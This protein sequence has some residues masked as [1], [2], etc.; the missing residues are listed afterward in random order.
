VVDQCF[1]NPARFIDGAGG[2]HDESL[3]GHRISFQ[4]PVYGIRD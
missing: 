1:R 4:L 2:S 3:V